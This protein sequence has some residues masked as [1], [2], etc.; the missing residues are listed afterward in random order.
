MLHA[1]ILHYTKV[2]CNRTEEQTLLFILINLLL[3]C[4]ILILGTTFCFLFYQNVVGQLFARKHF[5]L[6]VD[7]NVAGSSEKR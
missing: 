5:F 6:I 3:D 4:N 1:S 2:L 7:S